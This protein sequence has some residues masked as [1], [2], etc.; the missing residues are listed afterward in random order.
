MMVTFPKGFRC[1]VISTYIFLQSQLE[2]YLKACVKQRK[3]EIRDTNRCNKNKL[4][5]NAGLQK[6]NFI[7]KQWS[8][9]TTSHHL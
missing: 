2:K 9:Y 1:G 5:N 4:E 6:A 7:N 3:P 8:R